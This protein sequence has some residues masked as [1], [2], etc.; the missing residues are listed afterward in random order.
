MINDLALPYLIIRLISVGQSQIEILD[1]D[2]EIREDQFLLDF[3]PDDS[4]HFISIEID[5][6]VVNLGI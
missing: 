3:S 4:S 2:I 6:R 5:H 1:I